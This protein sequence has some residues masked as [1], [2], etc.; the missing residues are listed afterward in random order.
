MKWSIVNNFTQF[1]FSAQYFGKLYFF[2][3][4]ASLICI[5]VLETTG[6]TQLFPVQQLE[7]ANAYQFL[8]YLIKCKKYR[9]GKDL[10]KPRTRYS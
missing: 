4:Y 9:V 7:I 6:A 5:C 1:N 2:S 3:L 8:L 10:E